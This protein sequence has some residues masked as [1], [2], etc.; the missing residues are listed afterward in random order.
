[1]SIAKEAQSH[2]GINPGL[3]LLTGRSTNPLILST[4]EKKSRFCIFRRPRAESPSEGGIDNAPI[5]SR[6]SW[7][8]FVY[9][10]T[11]LSLVFGLTPRV[12]ETLRR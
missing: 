3:L 4:L 11:S 12:R 6:A 2:Q 8:I 9:F 1:M 10:I 7:G 5:R